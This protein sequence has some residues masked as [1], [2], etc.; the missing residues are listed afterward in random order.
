[1]YNYSP[2]QSAAENTSTKKLVLLLSNLL[3]LVLRGRMSYGSDHEGISDEL[4]G[5]SPWQPWDSWTIKK[6]NKIAYLQIIV[7]P[8]TYGDYKICLKEFM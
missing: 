4:A 8:V 2:P 3:N 6:K 1:M 5:K 7:V